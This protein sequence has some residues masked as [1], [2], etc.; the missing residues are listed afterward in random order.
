MKIGVVSQKGGVGKST[1]SRLIACE[2]ATSGWNVKIADMDVSQASTFNWQSRRLENGIEP[3]ISVE[4]FAKIEQALRVSDSYDLMVFDGAPHATAMTLKIAKESNLVILPTGISLDDLEPT[5]KLAHEFK[6]KNID[7][8]KIA[9]AL[10]RVGDS[11]A[12]IQEA[13]DYIEKTGYYLLSGAMPERTGYRRASDAGKSPTGTGF[14]SLNEK[15]GQLM[16][17][18]VNRVKQ[19]EVEKE[20][21]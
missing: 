8:M 21:K 5:I 16:Q 1:L 4:Q 6:Q 11:Q 19:V 17:S 12:E 18:I 7:P 2:Y 20:D 15:A 10:C 14:N 9:I 13:M 3:E